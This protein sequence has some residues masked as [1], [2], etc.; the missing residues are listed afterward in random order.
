MWVVSFRDASIVCEMWIVKEIMG[1]LIYEISIFFNHFSINMKHC[2]R[3]CKLDKEADRFFSKEDIQIFK[4]Y[5]R[6]SQ[7]LVIWETIYID[8]YIYY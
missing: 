4:K 1:Q 6:C 7:S 2:Q 3:V 5:E 8:M